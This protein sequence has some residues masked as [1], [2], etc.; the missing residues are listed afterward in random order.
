[1]EAI[2]L[3][4]INNPISG[5]APVNSGYSEDGLAEKHSNE[6]GRNDGMADA[7]LKLKSWEDF[8]AAMEDHMK[9]FDDV[10]R[11]NTLIALYSS[12]GHGLWLENMRT[13]EKNQVPILRI[14]RKRAKQMRSE[15]EKIIKSVESVQTTD[16][17]EIVAN[18]YLFQATSLLR[19]AVADL[20]ISEDSLAA[21]IHPK[22]RTKVEKR[23]KAQSP[24]ADRWSLIPDFGM[25][26]IE[27]MVFAKMVD[28][29]R[30]LVT[31]KGQSLRLV[32]MDRIIATA[33]EASLGGG[34][35]SDKVKT[36]RI[37]LG[38]AG[39]LE[40]RKAK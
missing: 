35:T 26:K 1:L 33:L 23:T 19:R 38:K 21:A 9:Q 39:L 12:A 31:K 36:A 30:S 16:S 28:F 17:Q 27:Y 5:S 25:A 20:R 32:E 40:S 2:V 3:I 22:F 15:I 6:R 14:D 29:L 34:H 4:R 37:R 11:E 10:M 13:E 7:N 24:R 8:S 18:S